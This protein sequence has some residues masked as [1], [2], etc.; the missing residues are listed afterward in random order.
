MGNSHNLKY[1]YSGKRI[2]AHM[3]L[4]EFADAEIHLDA[5]Q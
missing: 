2:T 1:I 3:F 5:Q 4:L